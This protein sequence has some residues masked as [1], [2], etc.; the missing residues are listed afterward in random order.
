VR[1]DHEPLAAGL[2]SLGLQFQRISTQVISLCQDY[3]RIFAG[4]N[5]TIRNQIRSARRRGVRARITVDSANIMAYHDVYKRHARQKDWS[6]LYPVELSLEIAKLRNKARFVVAEYEGRIIAG[7][8]FV[9]DGSSVVYYLHGTSDIDYSHMFPSCPVIAEGIRWA[10]QIG[11]LY[12]NLGMS[13]G[14]ASLERFKSFW[15]AH[16]EFNWTFEWRN[17]LWARL[18]GFRSAVGRALNV[19]PCN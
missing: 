10:C 12:F 18:Y 6:L 8:L 15:G 14:I 3:D 17:P 1:F 4:Y 16:A 5:A 7:G 13:G 11:A 9:R 19:F 2:A